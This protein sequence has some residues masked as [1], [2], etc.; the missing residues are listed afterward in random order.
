MV[1]STWNHRLIQVSHLIGSKDRL[2]LEFIVG[3]LH[4]DPSRRFTLGEALHHPFLG[5]LIPMRVLSEP[6]IRISNYREREA[7]I[8]NPASQTG[9]IPSVDSNVSPSLIRESS[10]ENRTEKQDYSSD[11]DNNENLEPPR[12]RHP[13]V[14]LS[15]SPIVQSRHSAES[16]SF[17]AH[18]YPASRSGYG[19]SIF[20]DSLWSR[21]RTCSDKLQ[22]SEWISTES[23]GDDISSFHEHETDITPSP[24]KLLDDTLGS[25]VD[26]IWKSFDCE[27]NT[28]LMSDVK[29][30]L[31]DEVR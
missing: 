6:S 20:A 30:N 9:T 26:D 3:M 25:L 2:F 11:Y 23:M 31:E 10:M 17:P 7:R 29:T 14:L 12:T 1:F 22:S 28:N 27:K 16:R 5:Y 13:I 15:S 21:T 18:S 19:N 8:S 4:Y 24:R